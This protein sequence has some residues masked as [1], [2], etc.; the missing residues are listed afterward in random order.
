[1]NNYLKEHLKV[2]VLNEFQTVTEVNKATYLSFTQTLKTRTV[3]WASDL[4][5]RAVVEEVL[6]DKSA[7]SIRELNGLLKEKMIYD[8]SIIIAE[9]LD[10]NG[11]VIS[12]SRG[13]RVGVDEGAEEQKFG[14]VRFKEAI[15][16]RIGEAYVKSMIVELD[17]FPE[18]M[19]HVTTRFFSIKEGPEMEKLPLDAVLLLHMVKTKE[20]ADILGSG[21]IDSSEEAPTN[22]RPFLRLRETGDVYLVNE[23]GFLLTPARFLKDSVLKQEIAT[24]P[25]KT[26]FE[27]GR[28]VF[29]EYVN[30]KGRVVFGG[31][32]CL[33]EEGV[34]LLI[35]AESKEIFALLGQIR[36]VSGLGGLFVLALGILGSFLFGTVMLKSVDEL[37]R[38]AEEVSQNKFGTRASVKS[39]NEIGYLAGVFNHML[40]II[41]REH[42]KLKASVSQLQESNSRLDKTSS[43]RNA[44]L[45]SIGDGLFVID[46][47]WNITQWNR[48]A[49]EISGWSEEEVIGK[50]MRQVLKFVRER[51]KTENIIFIEEAM[52]FA[53]IRQMENNTI[54]I[55]KDGREI[56]V[57]DSAG[58]LL[59][60]GGQVVGAVIIFRNVTEER[61]T[62]MLHSDFAYASHQLRT[63]V[64]E[65]LYSLEVALSSKDTSIKRESMEIAYRSAKTL[66]KLVEELIAV[67]EIDQGMLVPKWKSVKLSNLL[68]EI[69]EVVADK[70]KEKNIAI[71]V[72]P[73]PAALEI[74]TDAVLVKK[75]VFEI[76][77]N[78]LD[79][80]AL[81]SKIKIKGSI[82][83]NAVLIE[84]QDFGIGIP[85][86]QKSFVFTK[87]FR[88]SNIPSEVI[89]A[90]L[91]LY[92]ARG[93]LKLLNG[94][95]WF[96]AGK[97]KGTIFFISV[98]I[99]ALSPA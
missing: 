68:E 49:S 29:D 12:S 96:K 16:S 44:I 85:E 62:R 42:E 36:Y 67:S 22:L 34:V 55:A 50:P 39:R 38:A 15:K 20:L 52:L 66:A 11:I 1:M 3:D 17:E 95:I 45:K 47:G 79:Y 76:L 72:S 89:G 41:S 21:S 28:T 24:L 90:G 8:S 31:S 94:K 74:I 71:T 69:V 35:E 97:T 18:P 65:A 43:E 40:D 25:V 81:N 99:P 58:P 87:F 32:A 77:S 98:P 73:V 6:T 48:A 23:K 7:E 37:V 53:K 5:V 59:N 64:T 60:Q 56:P 83:N 27:T 4:K 13:D 9:V 82:E 51:D 33:R 93:Y 46:R 91:G 26:C 63:P 92:I 10:K 61:E 30:Y 19:M 57:T 78:A 88:G 14:A 80:S 86:E 84:I 70:A 54:L 75:A 2:Q